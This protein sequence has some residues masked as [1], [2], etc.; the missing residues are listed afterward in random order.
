MAEVNLGGSALI[1]P[2]P[3]AAAPAPARTCLEKIEHSVVSLSSKP[4]SDILPERSSRGGRAASVNGQLSPFECLSISSIGSGAG[5]PTS[6][7]TP[8]SVTATAVTASAPAAQPALTRAAPVTR[9]AV[10]DKDSTTVTKSARAAMQREIAF[11]RMQ[12]DAALS[13]LSTMQEMWGGSGTTPSAE[14]LLRQQSDRAALAAAADMRVEVANLKAELAKVRSSEAAMR[15]TF[16]THLRSVATMC[17]EICGLGKTE[18]PSEKVRRDL[19]AV[20]EQIKADLGHA[21]TAPG[22][23]SRPIVRP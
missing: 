23:R 12:R 2:Q 14:E 10:P 9:E 17:T 1:S 6:A 16:K 5:P 7:L 20:C 18:S 19:I 8:R 15:D 11:C 4:G 3:G 21:G 13:A 22:G